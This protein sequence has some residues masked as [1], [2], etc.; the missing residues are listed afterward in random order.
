MF[1]IW[2]YKKGEDGSL[3]GDR[4]NKMVK[5]SQKSSFNNEVSI[6]ISIIMPNVIFYY[7]V[8]HM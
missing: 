7:K 8:R 5:K 3:N 6:I 1:E 2:F 4:G